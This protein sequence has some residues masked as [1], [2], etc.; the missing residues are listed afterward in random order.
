[1]TINAN[2]FEIFSQ[3]CYKSLDFVSLLP[4]NV[5]RNTPNCTDGV[6]VVLIIKL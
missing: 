3:I 4:Y 1:M 6:G 5:S 2:I